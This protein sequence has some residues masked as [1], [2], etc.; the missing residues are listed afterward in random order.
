MAAAG[1]PALSVAAVAGVGRATV[2][3]ALR[4]GRGRGGRRRARVVGS[5][6]LRD[7][8][9][10]DGGSSCDGCDA[11]RLP[12]QR[13]PVDRHHER[14]SVVVAGPGPDR[15]FTWVQRTPWA[16][17]VTRERAVSCCESPPGAVSEGPVG[18]GSVDEGVCR[19]REVVA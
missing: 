13:L 14:P 7:A 16:G 3:V 12:V 19:P 1:A 4:G 9:S 2:R 18:T 11:R 10:Y 8:E 17:S 15:E 5:R 6:H